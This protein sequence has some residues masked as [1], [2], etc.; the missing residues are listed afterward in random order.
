MD[1][2]VVS[3]YVYVFRTTFPQEPREPAYPTACCCRGRNDDRRWIDFLNDIV[4]FACKCNQLVGTTDPVL[5]EVGFV[6]YFILMDAS[7]AVRRHFSNIIAPVI[8]VFRLRREAGLLPTRS[9]IRLRRRPLRRNRKR[10]QD[11]GVV[12]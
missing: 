1:V 5:L 2:E 8:N 9:H 10:K 12:R 4:S 7:L 11:F 6:P 3:H